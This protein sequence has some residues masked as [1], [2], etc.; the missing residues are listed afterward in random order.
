MRKHQLKLADRQCRIAELSQ[1]IQDL[2]T[3]LVT[4]QWANQQKDEATIAAADF[5]CQDLQRKLTGKR[6]S[7]RYFRD[8]AKLADVIIGGGFEAIAGIDRDEIMMPYEKK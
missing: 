2:V 7:D 6:P 5:L 1:R 8:A 3:I 4:A